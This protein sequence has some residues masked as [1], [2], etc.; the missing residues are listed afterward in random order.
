MWNF[1]SIDANRALNLETPFEKIGVIMRII[2]TTAQN[3]I[4]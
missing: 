3:L 1:V 2:K 4:Y